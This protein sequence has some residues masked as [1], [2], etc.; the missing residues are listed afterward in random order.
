VL[1][2]KGDSLGAIATK[3]GIPKHPRTGISDPAP[4]P[5]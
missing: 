4:V 5:R 2:A 1:K 3:T